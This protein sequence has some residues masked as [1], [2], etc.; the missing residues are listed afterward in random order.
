ME[1]KLLFFD[2]D[3]TLVEEKTQKVPESAI[4]ALNEAHKR[5]H[6][7]FINTGRTK[8]IIQ[9]CLRELP[10]DGY[11]YACGSHIE[12]KGEVLFER[13]VEQEDIN[14]IREAM[15]KTKIQ[16]IFQG[17]IYA[18][19]EP[20]ITYFDNLKNFMKIY[21]RDYKEEHRSFFEET[22]HINKL[23][24]FRTEVSDYSLFLEKLGG[25]YQLIEN[26]DG[27]TEILPLPYTKASCIDFLVEYFHAQL[28]D[29]YVFGDSPNDF[30]MLTHVENSIA[31]GNSYEEVKKI[32]KHVTTDIDKDGIYHAL[33][34][35]K[36]I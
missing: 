11:C 25:K 13:F 5:G 32:S 3:Q 17:P 35:F 7:L 24:T 30:P 10:F 6:F 18:Y 33:K 16:G 15:L 4:W 27:F 20:N 2:I 14:I 8:S 19:F 9:D 23:V 28:E 36:I 12:Y 31:M 26:K 22:M 29:C 1:R 21:E 34:H